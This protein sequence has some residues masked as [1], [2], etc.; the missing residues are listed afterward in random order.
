MTKHIQARAG[1]GVALLVL[2]LPRL[3]WACAVCNGAGGFSEETRTAF[4]ITTALL[5]LLPLAMIGGFLIWLSRRSRQLELAHSSHTD[6]TSHKAGGASP[7]AETPSE[8][9]A[10]SQASWSL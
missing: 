7:L 9:P 2:F 4:I 6:H 8:S 10:L 5:S 1:F 3:S